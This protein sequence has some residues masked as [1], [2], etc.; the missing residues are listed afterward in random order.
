MLLINLE[1]RI[2]NKTFW[3]ALLGAIVLLAQQLGFDA[4]TIIPKNYVDI[5][6]T[7][8]LILTILGVVVDTSTPGISDNVVQ[9]STVKA[10]NQ[11]AETKEEVKTEATTTS[12]N[13]TVTENSQDSSANASISSSDKESESNSSADTLSNVQVG[14]NNQPVVDAEKE[15]LKTENEQL[16]TTNE[17]LQS[18]VNTIQSA[19]NGTAQA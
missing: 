13:N 4:T 15:Q 11:A 12:I 2:K 14:T 9:D 1:S 8:F 19:V 17:Q 5:I 18:T 16:K 10:I 3:I 7:I 6:N